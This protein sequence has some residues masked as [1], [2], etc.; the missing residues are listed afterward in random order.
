M[1]NSLAGIAGKSQRSLSELGIDTDKLYTCTKHIMDN[2]TETLRKLYNFVIFKKL[3]C[4]FIHVCVAQ[5]NEEEIIQKSEKCELD[6]LKKAVQ[7]LREYSNLIKTIEPLNFE[8]TAQIVNKFE[9]F[10]QHYTT[11]NTG[12]IS[13]PSAPNCVREDICFPVE[14][15]Y[16]ISNEEYVVDALKI[17]ITCMKDPNQ[18]VEYRFI[19]DTLLRR[20]TNLYTNPTLKAVSQNSEMI[21]NIGAVLQNGD[22]DR[23]T[24][25][26]VS[27]IVN[28]LDD[29]IN[30]YT[31]ERTDQELII[32]AVLL[33]FQPLINVLA[34]SSPQD[35]V[36]EEFYRH[37]LRQDILQIPIDKWLDFKNELCVKSRICSNIYTEYGPYLTELINIKKA[38]D[39]AA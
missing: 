29:V 26:I 25:D 31:N 39:M 24:V 1:F 7:G 10:I 16:R 9:E 12:I 18:I 4:N 17:I 2:R 20:V 19:S 14:L 5:I 34:S 30:E 28:S 6:G 38:H 23:E 37:L 21:N 3:I 27:L 22:G 15:L 33:V 32:K 8:G 35:M 13:A 11:Y 36:I